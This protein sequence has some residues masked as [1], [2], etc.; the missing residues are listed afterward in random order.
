M[1]SRLFIGTAGWNIPSSTRDHFPQEGTHLQRYADVFQC[2]EINSSFYRDHQPKTYEKWANLTPSSFRFSVKL[3]QRFTHETEKF[4]AEDLSS[5]MAG[6]GELGEKL[7]VLL[8]QFPVG[9]P[10]DPF[11]L[12][13]LFECIRQSYFG[14]VVIE[15][16]NPNWNCPEALELMKIYN[17]SKVIAD[18]ERCDFGKRSFIDYGG[19][20]YLRYHG[21][22]VIYRSSYGDDVLKELKEKI[23]HSPRDIWCIF[24]NT[25]FGH[26]TE[27]AIKLASMTARPLLS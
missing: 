1:K 8:L 3:N 23:L 24:D 11:F 20:S 15:P 10:F 9:K 16:R 17:V 13:N 22:P 5:A 7:A 21:Q 25:T 2:V 6:Y 26:A 12:E 18:P 19:L 4:A 27:N 14:T